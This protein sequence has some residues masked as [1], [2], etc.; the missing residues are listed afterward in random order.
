M[1]KH[2]F[3]NELMV[4]IPTQTTILFLPCSSVL[5]SFST[6]LGNNQEKVLEMSAS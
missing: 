1:T 3:Y 2:H 4:S 6:Q 5:T